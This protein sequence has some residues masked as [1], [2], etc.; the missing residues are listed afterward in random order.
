VVGKALILHT[1]EDDCKTQPTGNS[2]DRLACGVVTQ[3]GGAT[4]APMT[5][6]SGQ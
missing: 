1:G 5:S 2:G 4:T 3:D 6:G